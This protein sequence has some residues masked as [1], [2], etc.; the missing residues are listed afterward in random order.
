[1]DVL[2]LWLTLVLLEVDMGASVAQ[3]DLKSDGNKVNVSPSASLLQA[4][5]GARSRSS[6]YIVGKSEGKVEGS[7]AGEEELAL[8]D[9]GRPRVDQL[10]N[11]LLHLGY[12][13]LLQ[14]LLG[15]PLNRGLGCCMEDRSY[16]DMRMY[17]EEA[18]VALDVNLFLWAIHANIQ[19]YIVRFNLVLVV[20]VK[21]ATVYLRS[22][23]TC[24]SRLVS[25][26]A[27]GK[28]H[29]S[30]MKAQSLPFLATRSDLRK[31]L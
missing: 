27:V 9:L 16:I 20:A 4:S 31:L 13:Q 24:H 17:L 3:V 25:A 12:L 19:T 8:G 11:A 30:G 2:I 26:G 29:T 7:H 5:E 15:L 14:V 1:M 23:N 10:V 18:D 6:A 28:V 21:D 22:S